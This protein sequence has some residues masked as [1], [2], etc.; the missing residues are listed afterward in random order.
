MASLSTLTFDQLE[1]AELLRYAEAL[2]AD[3]GGKVSKKQFQH[4]LNN[5]H[6]YD[7]Y[8]LVYALEI[9]ARHYPCSLALVL[10]DFLQHTDDS[11]VCAAMNALG[12]LP[13]EC[14]SE[15][16]LQQLG[17]VSVNSRWLQVVRSLQEK[18]RIRST[19][20]TTA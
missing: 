11:V 14:L 2:L 16:L 20:P 9:G 18:L 19:G 17:T 4:L 8:H 12:S 13:A 5:L 3:D 6:K 10:P 7:Q 1:G 15:R